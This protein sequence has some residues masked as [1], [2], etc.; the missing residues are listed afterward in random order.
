MEIEETDVK[1]AVPPN[2]LGQL[3]A[4][5]RLA[6]GADLQDL[7]TRSN[8]TV[9][10]L[11]DLEAGHRL[12]DD[13]LIGRV[14]TL[15]EIDC[16]LIVPQRSELV[17]DLD[18][19]LLTV[20]SEAL[21][22]DSKSRDHVLERYLSLVYL[23]RN[24]PPGSQVT[25]RDQ[26][27]NVLAASLAERREL[28]E[29]QLLLAMRPDNEAVE[30]LFG[31]FRKRLWVPAAGVL[32]GATSIGALVLLSTASSNGEFIE[33]ERLI[34]QANQT[35]EFEANAAP[36][37][38]APL[39]PGATSFGSSSSTSPPVSRPP[40]VAAAEAQETTPEVAAMGVQAE[41]L[42]PF[43]WE[44]ILPG[45]QVNYRG[46]NAGFRGLT[47]PYDQTIEIFVRETDTPQRVASILAHELG[48]A[49][50]VAHL[51][52]AERNMWLTIRGI[53][54]APWWPDAFASD[55]QSGAGDFAEA[56]AT[57][58]V[59]DPSS[60]EIAAQPTDEQIA[61]VARLMDNLS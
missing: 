38:V 57:W 52:P 17:I 45:W 54:D 14:T 26:D 18:D 22:L 61:F 59:D 9:G 55:F 2:R 4:E 24:N 44:E 15:Y 37:V 40:S 28:I 32:V 49:V 11:S 13:D 29:E 51:T 36:T 3:L 41:A 19:Q 27:L 7:A 5:A 25:L 35:T 23:L 12:L 16:G 56:F 1:T 20:A 42:L 31:W 53:E 34:A 10:E 60:S 33:P 50:D 8:F 48:H 47:Y 6:R 30:G 21:P 39:A 58:A 43:D 46:P